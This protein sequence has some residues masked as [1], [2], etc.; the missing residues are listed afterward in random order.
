MLGTALAALAGNVDYGGREDVRSFFDV[1]LL[2]VTRFVVSRY[3]LSKATYPGVAYLFNRDA[4]AL[5]S[6]SPT[7]G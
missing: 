1:L 4:G 2:E 7:D 5:M 6:C 3:N